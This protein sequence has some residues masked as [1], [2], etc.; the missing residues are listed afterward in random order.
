M[1]KQGSEHKGAPKREEAAS[2]IRLSGRDIDG[3]L[4]IQRAL[5]RIKGIGYNLSNSIAKAVEL[6]L[7][8]QRSTPLGSLSEQQ[9]SEIEKIIKDPAS[10]GIPSFMLNHN[11]D[12]E[13]GLP[14]HYV[15]ND[16][17]FTTRQDVNRDVSLKAWRGFRHQ[18]GQKV[19]GQHTRSTGRTGV[20]VGVTKKAIVAAQKEAKAAEKEPA[21][22]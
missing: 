19:R 5:S 7:G 11:K 9:I 18:Y 13:T 12:A 4:N 10:A 1:E 17:L 2:I 16:L 20:T 3:S 21:K 8:I 14:K 22:K 15:G 6:K